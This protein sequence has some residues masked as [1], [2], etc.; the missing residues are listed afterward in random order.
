MS[1]TSKRSKYTQQCRY[2]SR[3]SECY[4]SA[5]IKTKPHCA[6]LQTVKLA[7]YKAT[8]IHLLHGS[9][10]DAISGEAATPSDSLQAH[11]GRRPYVL[12]TSAVVL[13]DSKHVCSAAPQQM[14]GQ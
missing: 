4:R 9:V 6:N 5:A 12:A 7:T 13:E 2:E 3:H 10:N 11:P 14:H 1:E 8:V